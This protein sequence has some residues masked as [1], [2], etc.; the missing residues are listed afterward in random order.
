[1]TSI[2][3]VNEVKARAVKFLE[4]EDKVSNHNIYNVEFE[5]K[6]IIEGYAWQVGKIFI[7]LKDGY[8]DTRTTMASVIDNWEL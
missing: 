4:R 1:M 6:E 7:I 3:C 2:T 5:G 8:I